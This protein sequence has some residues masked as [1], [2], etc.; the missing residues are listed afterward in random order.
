M[1]TPDHN[2][3]RKRSVRI[4]GHLTSVS[5]EEPFWEALR[6]IATERGISLNALI[7][8]ID[9]KRDGNLSSALRIFAFEMTRRI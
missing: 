7:T 2:R 3:L 4:A 1:N 6:S 5:L 9:Q 8:D